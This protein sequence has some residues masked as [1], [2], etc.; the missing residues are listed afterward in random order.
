MNFENEYWLGSPGGSASAR[1]PIPPADALADFKEFSKGLE[2]KD[3]SSGE[4]GPA[5]VPLDSMDPKRMY[6]DS[7]DAHTLIIGGTGSGKSR[8]L[9]MEAVM[10]HVGS[11]E[12]LVVF[13]PKGEIRKR[14]RGSLQADGYM[15]YVI[16]LRNPDASVGWNMFQEIHGLI[17]SDDQ[18]DVDRAY[19]MV[20]SA[21]HSICPLKTMDDPFWET[22]AQ[23]LIAGMIVVVLK[24]ARRPEDVTIR[25]VFDLIQSTFSSED[26]AKEFAGRFRGDELEYGF[27]H[28]ALNNAAS[29]QRCIVAMA[30]NSLFPFATS[31]AL[32]RA[33]SQCELTFER[34]MERKTA[35]F[36]IA[37]DEKDTLNPIVS[38]F[39]KLLYEHMV[40]AAYKNNGSMQRRMNI[41]LDEFASLPRIDNMPLMLSAARSRNVR[42][43][44][45]V[46]SLSQLLSAYGPDGD[47]IKGNCSNWI[48][49]SSRD[50][51][52]LREIS[53]LVGKNRNGE[54]I[55]TTSQLQRFDKEAG[56]VLVLRERMNPFIAQL[57]D[58][59]A[60]GIVFDDE[61]PDPPRPVWKDDVR[62]P[63]RRE[64]LTNTIWDFD[65]GDDSDEDDD[66]HGS[67]EG[68]QD[69]DDGF[70]CLAI[71]SNFD[72]PGGK[73]GEVKEELQ[74]F[75]EFLSVECN[76]SNMLDAV[77]ALSRSSYREVYISLEG[78]GMVH[79]TDYDVRFRR[80]VNRFWKVV[81]K[82]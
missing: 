68:S 54:D 65:F 43:V 14:T 67:D 19:E 15:T 74:R 6:Y 34:M 47:T 4:P 10:S 27:M 20:M 77:E 8:R 25:K 72:V 55:L 51:S 30:T 48:F 9:I 24:S 56:Q 75:L 13:D 76:A 82:R 36:L 5:G 59:D 11:G 60:Y 44:L 79:N 45:A 66:G 17:H 39:V 62:E 78:N 35:V 80:A 21:A 29:T 26:A 52:T 50:M 58:I 71:F 1:R 81:G 42:F 64:P 41:I 70:L 61:I 57:S 33:L 31:N 69:I 23:G 22:S 18:T 73:A 38:I 28:P 49:M 16:D 40:S 7:R 46:Q 53:S 12:S 3:L 2:C 63:R 37:P 32:T